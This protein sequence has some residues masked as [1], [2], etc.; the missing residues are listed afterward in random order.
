MLVYDVNV[1]HKIWRIVQLTNQLKLTNQVVRAN[2][3]STYKNISA[4]FLVNST[5]DSIK[6][7]HLPPWSN[8]NQ[9]VSNINSKLLLPHTSQKCYLTTKII[10][11]F[12]SLLVILKIILNISF[13][14]QTFQR[15]TTTI[16]NRFTS[17][18]DL[19]IKISTFF[20]IITKL[21][22]KGQCKVIL[23][24]ISNMPFL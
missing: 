10:S 14:N 19:H 7:D 8:H 21:E 17:L 2:I 9:V 24:G 23:F 22:K 18:L 11:Y 15:F 5:I 20:T 3:C 1:Q 16:T 13:Y 4:P 12:Y 6:L